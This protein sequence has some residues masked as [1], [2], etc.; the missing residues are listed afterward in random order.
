[1]VRGTIT[2]QAGAVVDGATVTLTNAVSGYSQSTTTDKTG[3]YRLVNIPFNTYVL[4]ATASGFDSQSQELTIDATFARQVDVKLGVAPVRQ[5]V[6]VVAD[7]ALLNTEQDGQVTVI[8]RSFVKTFPTPMPSRG[9]EQIV[10]TAPG[11]TLDANGRLHSRG[12]EYQV[13]YSMDGIPITDTMASTFSSSPDPRIFRSIEVSN[14]AIPAEYGDKLAGLVNVTTLS[15]LEMPLSGDITISGGSFNTMEESFDIGG[16]TSK[17]GFFVSGAGTTTSRFLDPPSVQNFHNHGI[18]T[19][20]FAKLDFEPTKNDLIRFSFAFNNQ[21]FD[22]PNL[23]DQEAEGQIQTRT[24]NDNFQSLTWQ[25]IFSE[26]LVSNVAL[27]QRYNDAKL[28]SNTLAAPVYAEQSRHYSNYGA[29]GSVSWFK[30][31]NTI[32]AGFLFQRFPVTE[33]FTTAITNL[34]ELLAM[35]PDLPDE[36]Q[37]FTLANPFYFHDNQTGWEGSAYFQDHINATANLAFD[38][39][40]RFDSYHFLVDENFWS[41]RLG[42]SYYIPKT[43][44]VLR[45]SY[46]RFLETPAL[47]NLLLSSSDEA[48]VFSPAGE[49]EMPMPDAFGHVG[50]LGLTRRPH[51][52]TRGGE[53]GGDEMMSDEDKGAPVEASKEHQFDVGFQQQ[54][55]DYLRLDMDFYYRRLENPPEIVNFLETGIIFPA[56]LDHSRSKG[57]QTRLDLTPVRGFSGFVSWT[58]AHIYGYSPITGGLFLGEAVDLNMN[59]GSRVNI[60]EDQRNTVVYQARY[61]Y[62]PWR[63][64]FSLLGRFNSGYSVE[65]DP[66]ALEGIADEFPPEVLDRVNLDRG[67]IKPHGTADFSVGKEFPVNEHLSI[68]GQFNIDN[69]TNTFYLITFESVFSGTTIGPPRTYSG[70]VTLTFK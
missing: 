40:L 19:K 8:D 68:N 66:E 60:E 5:Q 70:R 49:E 25:H 29:L 54:L 38:L 1:M 42:V 11:W 18:S 58:N 7:S 23:P 52:V 43:H 56:N 35:Q 17:F 62:A 46:D 31:H 44:T 4:T 3:S 48:R 15:G 14:S 37:D 16:H 61:E 33:S 55:G 67:F 2:D 69:F 47:E 53:D 26:N 65:L 24:T 27:F 30:N 64:W 22:V 59:P 50:L 45:A 28:R 20:T 9:T 41:P 63:L 12:I 13:Q 39:G 32:K 34:D 6:E 51:R 21:G 10:S 57:I 36:A